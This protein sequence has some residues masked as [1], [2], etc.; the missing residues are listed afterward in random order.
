[1][2]KMKPLLSILLFLIVFGHSSWLSASDEK[3]HYQIDIKDPAQH[4]AQV[5]ILFPKIQSDY[6]DVIMP[7]WR[8]GR[9]QILPLANGVQKFTAKSTKGD[10]LEYKKIDRNTWRIQ[11]DNPAKIAVSYELY[12]NELA[13]RTRHID[14]THAYLDAVSSLMYSPEFRQLPVTLDINAPRGWDTVTGLKAVSGRDSFVAKNY[15]TLADSP[16]ETGFHEKYLFRTGNADF[17]VVIWGKGN[18]KGKKIA[19]DLARLVKVQKNYWGDYPFKRYVFIIHATNGARGAT[20][21]HNST[22]IQ[23]PRWKFQKKS[24][25]LDFLSTASHE[26]AHSWN[27]KSYRPEGIDPYDFTRENYSSLLWF[28]EGGTSYLQDQFLVQ[29]NLMTQKEFLKRLAEDLD[30]YL[31]KP[32]RFEMSAADASFNQWIALSGDRAVNDGVDI[33]LKGNMLSLWMD[34]MLITHS[35]GEASIRDIHRKLFARF[36]SSIRG[37]SQRDMIQLLSDTGMKDAEKQWKSFVL[38]T[39]ELPLINELK[40][41]GLSFHYVDSDKSENESTEKKEKPFSGITLKDK[42]TLITQVLK[43]SPAWE[44]KLTHNDRLV[45]INGLRVTNKNFKTIIRSMEIEK[46]IS[47]SYFRNDELKQ[48]SIKLSSIPD[49]KATLSVNKNINEE[50]QKFFQKWLGKAVEIDTPEKN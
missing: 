9:Y 45:A 24:D 39:T 30:R 10:N 1:M 22:V 8:P 19:R 17:E 3:V 48:T 40:K 37:Y 33:Y 18:Y 16:V 31:H 35:S 47:I 27:V 4:L 32:G 49:G 20:E 28:A 11:L 21:H 13:N 5:T 29:A 15:D 50:Q 14:S 43:H 6:I 46:K 41:L 42:T 36:P 26:F 12:A 25:Y 38:G 34:L 23:K 44:A 7:A 2:Y